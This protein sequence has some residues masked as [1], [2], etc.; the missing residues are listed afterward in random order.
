MIADASAT[1]VCG[2]LLA[3]AA[4]TDTTPA[5]PRMDMP[6]LVV[7]GEE[8]AITP[9]ETARA[10]AA[11]LPRAEVRVVPRAGHLSNLENPEAFDAALR[12]YLEGAFNR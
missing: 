3:M 7:A 1:G 2:A 11:R 4:R 9:P 6:A 10:M 5:L 8:D 12:D